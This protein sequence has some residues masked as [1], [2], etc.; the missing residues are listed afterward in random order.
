MLQQSRLN[1]RL[2]FGSRQCMVFGVS[3]AIRISVE[4]KERTQSRFSW[5]L[6]PS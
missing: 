1:K 2:G 3:T 6:G 4:G 5:G